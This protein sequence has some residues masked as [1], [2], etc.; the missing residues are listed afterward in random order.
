MDF[1]QYIFEAAEAG[2]DWMARTLERLPVGPF[3]FAE[4]LDHLQRQN[5][6]G[7]AALSMR[8][9]HENWLAVERDHEETLAA[10]Y[11]RAEGAN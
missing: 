6:P 9:A 11:L 2:D 10:S 7:W 4:A 1:Y 3:T 8:L 5:A